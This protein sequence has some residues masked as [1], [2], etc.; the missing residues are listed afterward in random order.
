[1]GVLNF[2]WKELLELL[3]L[4]ST[5]LERYNVFVVTDSDLQ[6]MQE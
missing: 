4:L 5:L 2:C 3:T 1:M 6:V